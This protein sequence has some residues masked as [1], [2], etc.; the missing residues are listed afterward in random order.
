MLAMMARLQRNV[1]KKNS[2]RDLHVFIQ[3]SA[4]IENI[5]AS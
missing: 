1:A 2:C 3:M 4:N 5:V